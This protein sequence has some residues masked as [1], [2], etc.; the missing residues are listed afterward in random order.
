MADFSSASLCLITMGQNRYPTCCGY[1]LN[2]GPVAVVR[3][4]LAAGADADAPLAD[5]TTPQGGLIHHRG[6]TLLGNDI[7]NGVVKE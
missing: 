1:L 2:P 5:G 7:T 4:L 6:E 3:R